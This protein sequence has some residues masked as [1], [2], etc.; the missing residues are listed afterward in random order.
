MAD[1]WVNMG[2]SP[3]ELPLREAQ[4]GKHVLSFFG[5]RA[6]RPWPQM[7][8]TCRPADAQSRIYGPDTEHSIAGVCCMFYAVGEEIPG[9]TANQGMVFTGQKNSFCQLVRAFLSVWS[10]GLRQNPRETDCQAFLGKAVC[11]H[12]TTVIQLPQV[13][14]RQGTSW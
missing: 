4:A 10:L 8:E 13:R 11:S 1:T 12:V 3:M 2:S 14:E 7:L 5:P 9:H 6:I